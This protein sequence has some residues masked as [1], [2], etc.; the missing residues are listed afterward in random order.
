MYFPTIVT[1]FYNIR[2]LEKGSPEDNRQQSHYLAIAEQYIMKLPYPVL[3]F[4]DPADHELYT[5]ITE[6]RKSYLDQ[7]YIFQQP[8]S[9]TYFYKDVDRIRELQQIYPIYNGDLKHET[10]LY[11][12]LNNNKFHFIE[13]AI[14]LNPFQSSHFI[15]MDFGINHVAKNPERIHDWIVAVPDK[16]RQLC[17]NPFVEHGEPRNIFHNIYHHMAGGLFSGN[18]ANLQKYIQAFKAKTAQIYSEHWWQVDEAV[19]TIV[20]RENPG[21]FDLF[22]GDY[23]GIISNYMAPVHSIY[24]LFLGISKCIQYNKLAFAQ[25][26]LNT[27][28]KYF[29]KEENQHGEYFYSYIRQSILSNYYVNGLIKPDVL[30]IINKQLLKENPDVIR[31]IKENQHHL[32]FYNNQLLIVS[33]SDYTP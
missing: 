25:H 2:A 15:W 33:H 1:A 5:F 14:A 3:F 9:A 31:I 11:V 18:I 20:Q 7:T 10:P 24:L 4:I 6:K 13:E 8:L 29:E 28:E 16:I 32:G 21:L 26:I 23:E 17:I 19:M 22:Y 12:V 27:L 30:R